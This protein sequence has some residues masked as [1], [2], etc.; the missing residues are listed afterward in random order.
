MPQRALKCFV[1]KDST[2]S[3][4]VFVV[5]VPMLGSHWRIELLRQRL[6]CAEQPRLALETAL[7]AKQS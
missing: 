7:P 3:M 5:E 2:R 1:S 4:A 6:Y